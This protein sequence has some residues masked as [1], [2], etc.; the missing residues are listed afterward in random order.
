MFHS[1]SLL[2]WLYDSRLVKIE[3]LEEAGRIISAGQ[4]LAYGL[5][6]S[7]LVE[8]LLTAG[9]LA[10]SSHWTRTHSI[11]SQSGSRLRGALLELSKCD[12]SMQGAVLGDERRC[13]IVF[14]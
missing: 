11:V 10:G 13:A 1:L 7:S 3:L 4:Q 14:D 5:V 8:V 2:T 6:S 12:K 9:G